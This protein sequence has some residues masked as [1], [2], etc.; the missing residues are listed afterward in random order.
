MR[1]ITG[2]ACVAI[3]FLLFLDA[4]YFTNY[5]I[6]GLGLKKGHFPEST[7]R[8][9]KENKLKGNMY[10]LYDFGGYIIYHLYPDVRVFIDGRTPT[11]YS[12]NFFF[13]SRMTDANEIYR[14]KLEE[15]Y[16]IDMELIERSKRCKKL[17]KDDKWKMIAFDDASVLFLKDTLANRAILEEW[18]YKHLDPCSSILENEDKKE[19]LEIRREL[20]RAIQVDSTVQW[21]HRWLGVVD[22]ALGGEYIQEAIEELRKAL[23][24]VEGK[25]TWYNYGL[26]LRKA[27]RYEEAIQ[28]LNKS[29]KFGYAKAEYTIGITYY[30]LKDYYNTIK[31]LERYVGKFADASDPQAYD[32]LAFSYYHSTDRMDKAI[33]YFKRAA[34]TAKEA[35]RSAELYYH[36][37]NTLFE[38][39][40]YNEA[41]IYYKKAVELDKKYIT[42]LSDLADK[43]KEA[44]R[45]KMARELMKFVTSLKKAYSLKETGQNNE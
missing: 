5:R 9:I 4:A 27:E 28:A 30:D 34:F 21:S 41:K 20:K 45:D 31:Y 39:D 37:G 16:G 17:L 1:L 22:T 2:A 13:K 19:L 3:F 42:V 29:L 8:F 23:D 10:N 14:H 36:L 6:Y 40:E 33:N 15:E 26:A 25:I 12:P 44:G 35:A 38:V 7:V 24:I 18:E 11:L 32:A 43:H